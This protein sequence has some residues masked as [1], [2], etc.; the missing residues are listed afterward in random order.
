MLTERFSLQWK[1]ERELHESTIDALRSD[2]AI[3][4]QAQFSLDEQK[5]ANLVLK[6]TIDR[7]RLDLDEIRNTANPAPNSLGPNDGAVINRTRKSLS[8]LDVELAE[9]ETSVGGSRASSVIASSDS[10]ELSHGEDG[11]EE[12]VITTRRRTV[13]SDFDSLSSLT[14]YSSSVAA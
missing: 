9:T 3:A 12:T 11:F 7:L 1:G 14:Y 13:S 5:A 8:T 4:Q 6:E 10:D 2:L